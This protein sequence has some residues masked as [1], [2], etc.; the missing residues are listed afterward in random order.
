M[1]IKIFINILEIIQSFLDI[2]K[3]IMEHGISIP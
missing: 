3:L 2:L 1:L